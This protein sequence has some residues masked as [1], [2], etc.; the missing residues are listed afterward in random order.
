MS[1]D[2]GPEKKRRKSYSRGEILEKLTDCENDVTRAVSDI[3][4]DLSPFDVTDDN[5]LAV[6]DRLERLDKVSG[7]LKTKIYKLKQAVQARKYKHRP[8]LLEETLI[9]CSQYSVLESEDS[10]EVTQSLS[11][12]SLQDEMEEID[13]P[14]TYRLQFCSFKN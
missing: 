3:V 2:V 13:R 8:E 7:N 11:Q 12:A 5:V 14:D 10:E 1:E 6:E 4:S 9:S